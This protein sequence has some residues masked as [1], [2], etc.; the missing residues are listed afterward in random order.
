MKKIEFAFLREEH[1][2]YENLIDEFVEQGGTSSCPF[3]RGLKA[4]SSMSPVKKYSE[5]KERFWRGELSPDEISREFTQKTS[6]AKVCPGIRDLM[7]NAIVVKAPC[8]MHISVTPEGRF[9]ANV[10]NDEIISFNSHD[11]QQFQGTEIDYSDKINLKFEME[12]MF[13]P[14]CD[15]IYLQPM[16]H[17]NVPFTVMNGVIKKGTTQPL[18]INTLF[19]IPKE[20]IQHHYIK[21]G[22]ALCYFWSTDKMKIK[23]KPHNSLKKQMQ[24]KFI[25]GYVN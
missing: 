15:M 22:T 8:D 6:T 14:Q 24:L 17:G 11:R 12:L 1:Y 23:L 20:G 16:Y 9:M 7:N 19:D 25:G 10:V 18:N 5:I 13:K 2:S 21:K 4:F 3:M